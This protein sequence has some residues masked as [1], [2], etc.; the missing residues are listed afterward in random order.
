MLSLFF[1]VN[2]GQQ[3]TSRLLWSF[4]RD[5]G[6]LFSKYFAAVSDT[7]EV[8]IWCLVFNAFWVMVEG[9]IYI[10]STVAFNAILSSCITLGMVSYAI[11][12]ALLLYRGRTSE[13]LPQTRGFKLRWGFGWLANAATVVFAVIEVVFFA[14]PPALPVSGSSMS[15]LFSM[16]ASMAVS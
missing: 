5:N 12:C 16:P 7:W 8:P 10:G 13:V 2:A 4:G 3:T 11:P 14:F 6:F 1:T 9:C 15:K